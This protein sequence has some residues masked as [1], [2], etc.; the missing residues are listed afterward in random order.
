MK[1]IFSIAL[2]LFCAFIPKVQGQTFYHDD[3]KM[4]QITTMHMGYGNLD[5]FYYWAFHNDYS[6]NAYTYPL[7]PERMEAAGMAHLQVDP[8]D[9][10]QSY[11]KSRAKEE[12]ANMLDRNID[13]VWIT[14]GGRLTEALLRLN[15]NVGRI[16]E[17]GA[18]QAEKEYWQ[19]KYNR[20][21]WSV[22]AMRKGYMPNSAR[23]KQFVA[24][25][26]DI[27]TANRKAVNRSVQLYFIRKME[28]QKAKKKQRMKTI[29]DISIQ[30]HN[31]W[32]SKFMIPSH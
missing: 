21:A 25:Y 30:A 28:Q 27:L 4:N 1:Q 29:H 2:I 15:R 10:I 22:D 7:N 31:D 11:L 14:E 6:R 32:C 20:L 16:G 24:L 26:G 3:I 12:V 5:N 23:K 18:P 8:A 13:L 17:Y 9:S 19:D